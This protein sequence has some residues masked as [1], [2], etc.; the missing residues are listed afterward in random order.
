MH[1]ME[2]KANKEKWNKILPEH[3]AQVPVEFYPKA[4]EGVARTA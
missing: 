3:V 4:W 2:P 1:P